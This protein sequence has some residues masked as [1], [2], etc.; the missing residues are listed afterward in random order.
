MHGAAIIITIMNRGFLS[1]IFAGDRV[2]KWVMATLIT[3]TVVTQVILYFCFRGAAEQ[4]AQTQN[5]TL[6]YQKAV[7]V[8]IAERV[9]LK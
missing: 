8:D 7:Q 1:F 3:F 4:R 5:R 6:E 9:K 2:Q